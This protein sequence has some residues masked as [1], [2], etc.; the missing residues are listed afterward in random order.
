MQ[1]REMHELFYNEFGPLI[2]LPGFMGNKEILANFLPDQAELVF[3]TEGKWPFRRDIA[4]FEY[5]RTQV[6]PDVYKGMTG[7]VAAQGEEWLKMRS[8]I[9]PIMMQPKIV[10]FYIPGVDSVAQE[11]VERIKVIQEPN[12]EMPDDFY[13]EINQWALE[14]IGFISMD[15]RWGVMSFKRNEE[16]EQIIKV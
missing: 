15:H 8:A 2:K 13:N 1:M 4:T 14:T 6:R 12:G 9:N 5:F 10:K 11:F 7:L 3:R 16:C